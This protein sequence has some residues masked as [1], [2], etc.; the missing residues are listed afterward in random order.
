MIAFEIVTL[1][2]L[3][4]LTRLYIIEKNK[5][6][7]LNLQY[8]IF[9][10]QA[11]GHA[12]ALRDHETGI[13]NIRVTYLSSLFG[14][15]L[16]LDRTSMQNLMKGA[17]LH[18]VGKIGISDTV[19]LKDCALN[20]YEWKIMQNH[21]TLGVELVKNMP[22]FNDAQDVILHHHEKYDGSGYPA[23]LKGKEIPYHARIFALIDVFDALM[24]K[25]PYKVALSRDE[26]IKII[27]ESTLSHFD[28]TLSPKFIHFI[29][30]LNTDLYL[31]SEE[32]LRELL[33]ARRK[34]IFGI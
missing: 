26:S 31:I 4:I 8:N 1:I 16:G 17:F 33:V 29:K 2:V 7:I 12:A 21:T 22:W 18:D 6:K 23:G 25:R 11:L 14:E 9:V 5:N 15:E 3:I 30:N 20:D 34:I 24:S 27:Q 28:P 19:L 32:N 13:H 10:A